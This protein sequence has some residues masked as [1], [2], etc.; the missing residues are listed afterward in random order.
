MEGAILLGLASIGYLMNRDDEKQS[1]RIENTVHPSY[2]ENTNSSI[3]NLNNVRDAQNYEKQLVDKQFKEAQD[4]TSNVVSHETAKDKEFDSDNYVRGLDG[5]IMSKADFLTNDQGVKMAPFFRGEGFANINFDDARKL[6]AHQGGFKSEFYR[7]KREVNINL[8]PQRN[9]GNVYGMK[10]TGRAMDQDRYIPGMYKQDERPFEQERVPHID[11]RSE[12]NRNI[13][14]IFAQKNSVDNLRALSNQKVS[15]GS[16]VIAG[17]G[18]DER[19]KIGQ[20]FKHNPDK[21]YAQNA[22]Q[23]LVTTGAIDAPKIRPAEILPET[24]R[25]YLNRQ[26]LGTPGSSIHVSNEKRPM[27]K[28]TTRQQLESDT[29]RNM[30]NP[31]FFIDGDHNQDSYKV[32]PN[33]REVTEERTYEGNVRSFISAETTQLQDSVKPTIKE[34]TLNPKSENGFAAPVTEVPTERLQDNVRT[35]KKE[36]LLYE[37]IGNAGSSHPQEMA[38]DQYFR[39]DL[40]PNK[41]IISKGRYPTPESTKLANGVDT[42]NVDIQKIESDY[43]NH[44]LVGQDKVYQN[45][46]TDNTCKYTRDKDTLNND[47]ISNRIEGDLL[48]PFKHNPYTHSLASFAY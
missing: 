14:E 40:N 42:L 27:F 48:A 29:V 8:P 5:N 6:R 15:F 46:P 37:H 44:R 20:V 17:K 32:Y 19:G 38:Q 47:K 24:N 10:D 36:T 23:W 34:T 11:Q 21:D 12:I 7:K 2:F 33:E 16:R 1:H 4:P 22:G 43:F 26:D 45:I 3:Y 28:K 39:A 35:N 30:G 25:Q 13:G 31:T 41:E 9:V 18:V